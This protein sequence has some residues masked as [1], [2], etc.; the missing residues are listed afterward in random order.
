MKALDYE[1]QQLRRMM[2]ADYDANEQVTGTFL[3]DYGA[4]ARSID[5]ALQALVRKCAQTTEIRRSVCRE[6]LCCMILWQSMK[7]LGVEHVKPQLL[8]ALAGKIGYA[9]A[10]R[11]IDQDEAELREAAEMAELAAGPDDDV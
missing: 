3:S 7:L 11:L 10:R 6:T 1:A 4:A 8:T 9:E 5:A 2:T